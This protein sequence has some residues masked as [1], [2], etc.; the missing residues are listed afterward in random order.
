[1]IAT[2]HCSGEDCAHQ[3]GEGSHLACVDC[4]GEVHESAATVSVHP[5][6]HICP[7]CRQ[8]RRDAIDEALAAPPSPLFNLMADFLRETNPS[9]KTP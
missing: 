1:M 7:E 5:W 3:A 9:T 8:A 2:H 4:K 6:G